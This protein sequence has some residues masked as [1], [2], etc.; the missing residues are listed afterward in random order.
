MNDIS[1]LSAYTVRTVHNRLYGTIVNGWLTV[2][3]LGIALNVTAVLHFF[4]GTDN[5]L[6]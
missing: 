6:V 3:A 1:A 2:Y 4:E 5:V